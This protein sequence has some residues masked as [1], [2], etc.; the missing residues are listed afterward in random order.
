MQIRQTLYVN[1]DERLY[2]QSSYRYVFGNGGLSKVSCRGISSFEICGSDNKIIS[3]K[4]FL[5]QSEHN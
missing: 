4:D 1:L 3:I 2:E 5:L